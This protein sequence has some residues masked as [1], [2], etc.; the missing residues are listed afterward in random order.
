MGLLPSRESV[1]SVWVLRSGIENAG[2][3]SA[4]EATHGIMT[5]SPLQYLASMPGFRS[6]RQRAERGVEKTIADLFGR[7]MLLYDLVPCFHC[8]EPEFLITQ[9]DFHF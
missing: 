8:E 6:T 7:K 9:V 5:P 2:N 3:R 4:V 1:G